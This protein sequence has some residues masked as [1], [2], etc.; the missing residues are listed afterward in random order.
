MT[1]VDFPVFDADNHYY[2]A[3]DA[4]TRHMDPKL[5]K[6]GVQWGEI[7]G[8]TR[9]LVGG[10]I[11]RFIPNPTFDPVSRPGAL[12]EYFR[13][14]NPRGQDVRD[15]FGELEPVRPEYR[16]HDARINVMDKQGLEGCFLFPTLGVGV[17]EAL[18]TDIDALYASLHAFNEWL[19]EDWGFH[20]QQRIFGA[21]MLSLL[22]ERR[23][24]EE[25]RWVIERGVRIVCLRT[26]P[27]IT[28]S[29]GRSPGD[30]IY[31]EFWGLIEDAGV[32]VGYHSG[33]AGYDRYANDWGA[34][35]EMEAFRADPFK[36]VILGDRPIFDTMAALVCHG[37]FNRFPRIK[38]ATIESGSSWVQG[39]IKSLKKTYGQLPQLFPEDPIEAFFRNVWVAPFF[40]DDIPALADHISVEHILMGSDWPHAEGLPEPADYIRDLPGF[41]AE[42][43]RKIMHDNAQ[44]LISVT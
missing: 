27:L 42:A 3:V 23:A 32:L 37:V 4:F 41:S 13:G 9:I 30:P 28:P 39:L 8:R 40:E 21:P 43:V 18:R 6:R 33:D 10:R 34:S 16:D 12:D 38:V 22:D 29:G 11:F 1:Q 44:G 15:A 35:S 5:A 26:G 24:V 19:D 7:N 2:E 36:R 20:Y 14:R 17:E 25:L 31:D